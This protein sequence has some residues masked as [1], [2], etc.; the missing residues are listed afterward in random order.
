MMELGAEYLNVYYLT[1]VT[2]QVEE[3]KTLRV[4]LNRA[5]SSVSTAQ[6]STS[7]SSPTLASSLAANELTQKLTSTSVSH[8][9]FSQIGSA[10]AVS[11]S[12]T[13]G[14]FSGKISE[15]STP[16]ARP[17]APSTSLSLKSTQAAAAY[18]PGF[19][20]RSKHLSDVPQT[21]GLLSFT[22][23]QLP[24]SRPGVTSSLR[25]ANTTGAPGV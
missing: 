14:K 18:M 25:H 3:S 9:M 8:N 15:A 24:L 5:S 20:A 13:F 23:D 6:T 22:S 21:G 10:S 1:Q 2:D 19:D 11:K 12:T 17:S 16:A 4:G 7:D